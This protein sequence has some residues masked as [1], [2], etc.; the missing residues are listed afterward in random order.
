MIKVHYDQSSLH[1][2]ISQR[3]R[4]PNQLAFAALKMVSKFHD[5]K[6]CFFIISFDSMAWLGDASVRLVWA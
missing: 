5:L 1:S 2:V 4:V 6:Q 3:L